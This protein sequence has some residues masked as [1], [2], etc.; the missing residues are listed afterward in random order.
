MVTLKDS[1]LGSV[2]GF[3]TA[4]GKRLELDKENLTFGIPFQTQ[5]GKDPYLNP[6]HINKMVQVLCLSLDE[7]SK[8]ILLEIQ[9]YFNDPEK[10]LRD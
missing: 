8:T 9:G 7:A 1:Y 3:L 2:D 10:S 5:M 6:L 4:N